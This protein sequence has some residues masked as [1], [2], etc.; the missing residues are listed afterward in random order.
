MM[1][2]NRT[3]AAPW[4]IYSDHRDSMSMRDAG[5]IQLYV[6]NVQE[7]LDMMIQ[8][9]KLAEHRQVQTPVMSAWTDLC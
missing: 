5:W 2:A 9:Y 4:N 1:N 7:A 8:A 3:V 6:E